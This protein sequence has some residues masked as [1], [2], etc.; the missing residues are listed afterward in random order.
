MKKISLILVLFLSC[1][2]NI[3]SRDLVLKIGEKK[4][5]A[6]EHYDFNT[7]RLGADSRLLLTGDTKILTR[8]LISSEGARIQYKK[9][10]SRNKNKTLNL[11]AVDC[12][13][14]LANLI[15]T[16][17]GANGKKGTNGKDGINGRD[18]HDKFKLPKWIHE[19]PTRG[20]DGKKGE[21]GQNGENGMN[22]YLTMHKLNPN[23][24]VIIQSNG[25][26]GGKGG[27]GGKGGNGGN[28]KRLEH[29]ADGGN[30][31]NGGRGGKGGNAGFV[32]AM[33]IYKNGT[34]DH[35]LKHLKELLEKNIHCNA[36]I[37]GEGGDGGYGG[38][39]GDGGRKGRFPGRN[40]GG[41]GQKGKP[42][43]P[44]RKGEDKIA[45]K[46]LMDQITWFQLYYSPILTGDK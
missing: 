28:G 32:K 27:T 14:V 10:S 25:G 9:G 39:Y 26:N 8:K 20:T 12:S 1:T 29:G 15:L 2:F 4:E 16:G 35:I 7:M 33:L 34:P 18:E 11:I 41:D 5:L 3:Y 43:K 17:D 24:H 30:G 19:D 21:P 22:I 38:Y 23:V 45:K 31:G 13:G 46:E 40:Y 44:G 42:G 37:G 6:P 36:G